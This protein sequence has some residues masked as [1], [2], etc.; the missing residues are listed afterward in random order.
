MKIVARWGLSILLLALMIAQTVRA[1]DYPLSP[2]AIREAYFLGKGDPNKRA[3]FF[4][5][6]TQFYPVPQSG[7]YVGMIEFETPYVLIAERVSQS[8]GN[9]FAQDAEQ[10]Y[11]GKPA[12]CRVLVQVDYGGSSVSPTARFQTDYTVVLKQ[13][14]KEISSKKSWSE[15]LISY[16]SPY[17]DLGFLM[18]VE[19]DAEKI[20]SDAPL[21]VDVLAPDGQ[22]VQQTFELANLR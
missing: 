13:N 2:E 22:N 21:T 9:Y 16:G 18:D 8:V 20:D 12:V 6:Y 7:Q 11:L 14:D 19:Y 4:E 1:Y 17:A 3:E 10:D 5:K 15:P